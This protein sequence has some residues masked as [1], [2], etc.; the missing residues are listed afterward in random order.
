MTEQRLFAATILAHASW[1]RWR[2][3]AEPGEVLRRRSRDRAGEVH[4]REDRREMADEL[5]L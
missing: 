2:A 3:Q 4:L 5:V 1:R